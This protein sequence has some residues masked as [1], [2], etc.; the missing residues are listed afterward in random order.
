MGDVHRD[1]VPELLCRS[2]ILA[3]ARPDNL[4]S[5]GGFPTK[6]GEYLS[7]GNLVIITDV[8][9]IPFYLK[10]GESALIAKAGI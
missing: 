2:K 9:D 3:L 6:L 7:T 1:K 5:E 10:D 4:Q 8:G